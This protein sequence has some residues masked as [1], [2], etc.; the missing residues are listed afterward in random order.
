[1]IPAPPLSEEERARGRRLAIAS[2]V[3][4]M[5]FWTAFTGQLPTL[6]LVSLGAS[7][8][9]IG[10]QSGLLMGLAGIQLP[11]LRLISWFPKRSILI[12]GQLVAL[13]ASLPLVFFAATTAAGGG[14]AVAAV[15]ACLAFTAAGLTL[16]DLVW[17]PLLR[18]YVDPERVGRFFGTIRTTWHAAVIVFFLGAQLWLARHETGF[19]LLFGVAWALGALRIALIARLP[20]RSER[21][22]ERLRARDALALVRHDRRLRRYM[23]GAIWGIAVRNATT[24]FVLVMLRR[25]LGFSN[26]D[27]VATT[28][29]VYLGGLVSLYLWGAIADRLGPYVVFRTSALG[30]GALY[31]GLALLEP[32]GAATQWIAIAFFFAHSV[33]ASGHGVADTRL[34]FELAPAEAPAKVLVVTAVV[35]GTLCGLAPALAGAVLDPL[36]AR[37]AEPLPVYHGFFAVSALL[38]SLSFLPLREFRRA[39]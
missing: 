7:E 12:T 19:G 9:L 28:V 24:P 34:L 39:V 5:T 22:G 32:A 30:I 27:A 20:E 6:A 4:S 17:F 2:N 36:L 15:F 26:S 35:E 29:A 8:T 16:S 11:A 38:V 1:V 33:L 13:T 23:T 31:A 25:A 14:A 37:A 18:G 10:V 21:G 3:P